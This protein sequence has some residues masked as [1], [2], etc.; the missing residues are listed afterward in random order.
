MK[1]FIKKGIALAIG[2]L[3]ILPVF[4]FAA[5]AAIPSMF[6]PVPGD[7][8][9]KVLSGLF[10]AGIGDGSG[11]NPLGSLLQVFNSGILFICGITATWATFHSIATTAHDGEML[12]KTV[13]SMWRPL[14]LVFW[15]AMLLPVSSGLNGAEMLVL[16]SVQMGVGLADTAWTSYNQ[17]FGSSE[18]NVSSPNVSK[19][20]D[21]TLMSLVCVEASKKIMAEV[22][23]WS[24][25]QQGGVNSGNIITYA[26]YGDEAGCGS[27]DFGSTVDPKLLTEEGLFSPPPITTI[28]TQ[29]HR[30]AYADLVVDLTPIAVKYA[31]NEVADL[32]ILETA[33]I[34]YQKTVMA[35]VL[36]YSK[37]GGDISGNQ[38]M[39]SQSADSM[40]KSGW[41]SAGS[42]YI[43]LTSKQSLASESAG[44]TPAATKPHINSNMLLTSS[45]SAQD[46][47]TFAAA[48]ISKNE[49]ANRLGFD[50]VQPQ[51]DTIATDADKI[52]GKLL[53]GI[54]LENLNTAR[55]P[56]LFVS[57]LGDR[58]MTEGALLTVGV[59]ALS[60]GA[61]VP[62]VGAGVHAFITSITPIITTLTVL[63]WTIG[64][65]LAYLLPALPMMIFFGAALS[66]VIF[67]I[68][69]VIG[70]TLLAMAGSQDKQDMFTAQK[71][72]LLL[73]LKCVITPFL[74]VFGMIAGMIVSDLLF[75]QV[76]NKIMLS[77]LHLS[78]F[79]LKSFVA[80]LAGA[81]VYC[82][83][84][85]S[86]LK[87][88]F[89]LIHHIPDTV[90][91]FIGGSSEAT[92]GSGGSHA[93]GGLQTA[94][95]AASQQIGGVASGMGGA[96][97][98]GSGALRKNLADKAEAKKKAL[99]GD[100]GG[101]A[102]GVKPG[103]ATERLKPAADHP[104]NASK[105]GPKQ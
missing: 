84:A 59:A 29:S 27:V 11:A 64:F 51:S 53:T 22:P 46:S 95:L 60:V 3:A 103:P 17:N 25:I 87:K 31:N 101:D 50:E 9:I 104:D 72:G 81:L 12:G 21:A 20:E 5:D 70:I 57:S 52:I 90:M 75:G 30:K 7:L 63:C 85:M 80:V 100:S 93:A 71:S 49:I 62:W 36:E 67:V 1:K 77:S 99:G 92:M 24:A 34:K 41:L 15:V 16:K 94:T 45:Q 19:L 4:A 65:S 82:V 35:A 33:A 26:S 89:E 37:N 78:T 47:L 73:L 55:H 91:K 97:S 18:I 98:G 8:S 66:W 32:K 23:N 28:I 86:L 96:I 44:R 61:A 6:E 56:I 102:G 13:N 83:I 88:S 40:S 69:A 58:F 38:S 105:P 14:S 54:D 68:E 43:A 76:L 79:G 39:S 48:Q 2:S 42:Y 74:M 10:G